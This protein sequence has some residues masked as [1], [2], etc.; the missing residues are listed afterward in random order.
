[1]FNVDDNFLASVG[2]D[3]S[4]LTSEQKAQY[5]TEITAELKARLADRLV[6]E[7]D[8]EQAADFA[9][10]QGDDERVCSWLQEFHPNYIGDTNYMIAEAAL[11]EV[12][13]REF[14]ATT[15]WTQDAVPG[16]VELAQ[17][18]INSYQA[19]LVQRR[20]MANAALGL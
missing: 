5:I 6:S 10:L 9:T 11:G 3:V 12:D 14:Y 2:Y 16:Y 1:M 17:E 7:I 15:M 8:E 4:V 19:E 18:I 13:G 20:Q